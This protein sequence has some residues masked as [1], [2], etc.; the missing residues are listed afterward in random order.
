MDVAPSEEVMTQQ[1]SP[2]PTA[3]QT[4]TVTDKNESNTGIV[5]EAKMQNS[6]TDIELISEVVPVTVKTKSCEEEN[7]VQTIQEEKS[8]DD[9]ISGDK[10]KV[11][12]SEEKV[13]ESEENADKTSNKDA[14]RDVGGLETTDVRQ[15]MSETIDD[16]N[17]RGGD[18]VEDMVCESENDDIGKSLE[19]GSEETMSEPCKETSTGKQQFSCS[20]CSKQFKIRKRF[21]T[22]MKKVHK[23]KFL[24]CQICKKGYESQDILD[25]HLMKSHTIKKTKGRPRFVGP[26]TCEVC[27]KVFEKRKTFT[28]HR[29]TCGTNKVYHPCQS[30]SKVF[31]RSDSL[32]YHTQKYHSEIPPQHQCE[33]CGKQFYKKDKLRLHQAVHLPIEQQSSIKKFKCDTCNNR[34]CSRA[35]LE[36]HKRTHTGEKPCLCEH[37][38]KCFTSKRDA[39]K[40]ILRIHSNWR[41]TAKLH[42][43]SV[44]HKSFLE[45]S[46]M[47]KHVN[48]VHAG[49]RP[50]PCDQ[51]QYRGKN[52]RDLQRHQNRHMEQ[53]PFSCLICNKS[54]NSSEA[55]NY[56]KRAHHGMDKVYKCTDCATEFHVREAYNHH[57]KS[58]KNALKMDAVI[59]LVVEGPQADPEGEVKKEEMPEVI[60]EDKETMTEVAGTSQEVATI[61]FVPLTS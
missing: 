24:H 5:K 7:D 18:D 36:I 38:G 20:Q 57:M 45:K 60:V 61:I 28:N 22:H 25:E 2:N 40:H 55:L 39:K 47:L 44:C 48:A 59:D 56:H 6:S 34:Y 15:S 17:E 16:E 9:H 31:E 26:F 52:K 4:E 14:V 13:K 42:F 41:E 8:G 11:K 54:Y 32:K 30:C 23:H 51:C 19:E 1:A 21:E 33:V 53:K 27:Q 3:Q 35:E 12:E 50:F 49:N 37:C 46:N 43:C 29:R 58:H 10:E